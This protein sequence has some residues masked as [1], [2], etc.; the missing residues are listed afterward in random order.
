MVMR[1]LPTLVLICCLGG[2]GTI[3][4]AI[5]P[6]APDPVAAPTPA[7]A[8]AVPT[9]DPSGPAA[10]DQKRG[11]GSGF[12][13]SDVPTEGRPYRWTYMLIGLAV[14]SMMG[15]FMFWL[16]RRNAGTGTT[17]KRV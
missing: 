9:P 11:K 3:A 17:H 13:T 12:W 10:V 14:I 5:Q 16:I 7:G 4:E 6:V 1:A 2:L 8:T 15:L